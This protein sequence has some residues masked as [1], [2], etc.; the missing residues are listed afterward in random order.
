MGKTSKETGPLR[1][2]HS[3][4]EA[5]PSARRLCLRYKDRPLLSAG[6]WT[7]SHHHAKAGE[8]GAAGA[9]R[10]AS[11]RR[12]QLE[13]QQALSLDLT[14]PAKTTFWWF[15]L[16][17]L[18]LPGILCFNHT[19]PL[20]SVRKDGGSLEPL[21]SSFSS[22]WGNSYG[23]CKTQLSSYTSGK[24]LTSRGSEVPLQLGF[25]GSHSC[26]SCYN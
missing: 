11:R 17:L 5:Q 6:T 23:A 14:L 8:G 1:P 13:V 20:A 4:P 18:P 7:N 16:P 22:S 24:P 3:F 9:V 21:D 19:A 26:F 15:S 10:K 2:T 25:P 12:W